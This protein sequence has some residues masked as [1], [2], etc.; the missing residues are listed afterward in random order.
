MA[1]KKGHSLNVGRVPWNKGTKGLI[2]PNAGSFKKG[3]HRSLSTEFKKVP[4]EEHPRWKGDAVGYGALH[5][6]VVKHRGK[7]ST[8][9]HCG[10]S[11]LFGMRIHWA[12]ISG[13]YRRDL[14]DWF[15]L[16][17]KCHSKYD[18]SRK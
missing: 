17:V 7:P 12:N 11:K 16:C 8:C 1:F 2:K 9:E 15:R 18:H 6:W 14:S 3:E 13:E 10:K 5:D 4:E